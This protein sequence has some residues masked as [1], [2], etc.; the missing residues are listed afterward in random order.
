MTTGSGSGT[1]STV[2]RGLRRCL[3]LA[4]LPFVAGCDITLGIPEAGLL[5]EA[6]AGGAIWAVA[7]IV[8]F[9]QRQRGLRGFTRF[10]AFWFGTPTTWVGLF[11]VP[12]GSSPRLEPPP[13]DEEGLL[14]EVRRDRALRVRSETK[15][16]SADLEEPEETTG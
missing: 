8:Y 12:E 14:R 7:N 13:D 2:T 4:A 15:D 11:I 5:L 9:K 6:T 10:L 16:S 1:R 3:V